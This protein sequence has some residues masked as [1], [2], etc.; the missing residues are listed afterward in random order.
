LTNKKTKNK[1]IKRPTN[2]L[3]FMN[4]ILL[5]SYHRHISA[6]HVAI[7]RVVRTRT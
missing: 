3:G 4:V 7:V 6:T 5:H 1:F 2:A